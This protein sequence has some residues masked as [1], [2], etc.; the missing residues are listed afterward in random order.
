MAARAGGQAAA[1]GQAAL[2]GLGGRY[3]NC[4]ASDSPVL[5]ACQREYV[6][7]QGV[8]QGLNGGAVRH[9][10]FCGG[11]MRSC[12]GVYWQTDCPKGDAKNARQQQGEKCR[13]LNV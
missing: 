3:P 6:A 5:P 2:V 7:Q 12:S 13:T 10:G 9:A 4:N 8:R 11:P 1:A